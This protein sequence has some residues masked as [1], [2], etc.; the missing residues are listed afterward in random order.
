MYDKF[1]TTFLG[2]CSDCGRQ[3][4]SP[5]T[6]IGGVKLCGLCTLKYQSAQQPVKHSIIFPSEEEI[7]NQTFEF[8]GLHEKTMLRWPVPENAKENKGFYKGV[9]WVIQR[10]KELNN[11]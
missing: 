11:L 4:E 8:N 9:E 3:L 10:I 7:R 1:T 6:I 2:Y 5:Y